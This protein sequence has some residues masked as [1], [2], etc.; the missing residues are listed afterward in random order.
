MRY[1]S[2]FS[3]VEAATLA[4]E[5]LGWE[6][7]AFAQYDPTNDYSKGPDFPSA[8]L[9][10]RWPKI[11]N[12]G[13]ITKIKESDIKKLGAIDLVVFGSPCQDLSIAGKQE[14]LDGERSGLFRTA[15]KIIKWAVKHNGCRLALWENVP[16][17]FTSNQGDDFCEVLSS[18]CGSKLSK[19]EKWGGA[20]CCF[21]KAGLV[22]WATLDAQFF[23]EPQR[24]RRV[25]ALADFGDWTNRTPVLS[26]PHGMSG[27]F[28]SSRETQK[29]APITA[30]ES[31]K[32]GSHWD[33]PRN[34]HPTLNQSHNAGGIAMSNQ[35]LF[36]QRGCGLVPY[37]LTAFGQYGNGSK[38]STCQARDYKGATDLVVHGTQDP[39]T[40][41]VA[42]PIGRNYGQENVIFYVGGVRR[43]TPVEGERLQ[44]M[45]DNHTQ[46]PW[47][48]KPAEACPDGPRYQAIGNSM[49]VGTMR[50]IGVQIGSIGV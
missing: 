25:F 19:P 41:N 30:R 16:G 35:E 39:I 8:V 2:L 28:K 48:G 14:G 20:G 46:I 15:I 7:V 45:P 27:D 34:P 37:D 18:L 21:G 40:S 50:W 22:E 9:D 13:D 44:G 31:I 4:W 24:R 1:L 12:L 26:Q 29:G 6:A 23:G 3:G 43:L 36:S 11:P 32:N 10:Y 5:P 17:A 47:R 33:D 49:H 38:A 42:F